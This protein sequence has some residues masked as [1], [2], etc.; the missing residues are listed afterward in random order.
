ML[1]T[2]KRIIMKFLM[3]ITLCLMPLLSFA[4]DRLQIID[5][6]N[7]K[8]SWEVNHYLVK[9]STRNRYFAYIT[10]QNDDCTNATDLV[11]YHRPL[12]YETASIL[13]PGYFD[14]NSYNKH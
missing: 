8:Y 5:Q 4:D 1:L 12:A 3:T 6:R 10:G 9:D 2:N 13:F 7:Y 14:E 11:L